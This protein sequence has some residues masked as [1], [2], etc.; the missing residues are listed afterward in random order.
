[1][2]IPLFYVSVAH[3]WQYVYPRYCNNN[4]EKVTGE[5]M[6]KMEIHGLSLHPPTWPKSTFLYDEAALLFNS[7]QCLVSTLCFMGKCNCVMNVAQFCRYNTV[8]WYSSTFQWQCKH[9]SEIVLIFKWPV[10]VCCHFSIMELWNTV[11]NC[12]VPYKVIVFL[13]SWETLIGWW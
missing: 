11:M 8:S 7:L 10:R 12:W 2:H 4:S 5:N 6:K 1:M 13:T 9:N 3:L